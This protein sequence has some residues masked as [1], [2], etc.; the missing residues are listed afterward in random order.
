M[1]DKK[2]VVLILK[3]YKWII[4]YTREIMSVY[5]QKHKPYLTF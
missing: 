5:R 3:K 2:I 4:F 1:N